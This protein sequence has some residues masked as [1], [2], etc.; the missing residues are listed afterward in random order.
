MPT[1]GVKGSTFNQEVPEYQTAQGSGQNEKPAKDTGKSRFNQESPSFQ[2]KQGKSL[3]SEVKV[4][5][6]E[7]PTG[8]SKPMADVQK[9]QQKAGLS[10]K[11]YGV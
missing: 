7:S 8:H 10:R 11:G 4:G 1:R 3:V 6:K 2:S 9:I 5:A